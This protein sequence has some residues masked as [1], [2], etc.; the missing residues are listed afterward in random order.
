[1]YYFLLDEEHL[2]AVNETLVMLNEHEYGTLVIPCRPSSPDVQILL[3][4]DGDIV[5]TY[6]LSKTLFCI[7]FL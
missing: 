2:L 3:T 7:V 6:F 4:K 5:S 1:M